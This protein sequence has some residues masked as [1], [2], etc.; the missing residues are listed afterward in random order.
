LLAPQKPIWLCQLS[1]LVKVVTNAICSMLSTVHRVILAF[2]HV[3]GQD[4]IAMFDAESCPNCMTVD[5]E[6][7]LRCYARVK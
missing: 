5:C 1:K 2:L 6:G 4:L 7:Y 3:Q